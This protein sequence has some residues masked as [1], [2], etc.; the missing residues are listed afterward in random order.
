[1]TDATRIK[2]GLMGAAPDTGNMGVS[3]LCFSTVQG[4]CSNI[5]EAEFTVFDNGRGVRAIAAKVNRGSIALKYC[6]LVKS[7]KF[8][9]P[10]NVRLNLLCGLLPFRGPAPLEQIRSCNVVM[11]ISGGDSF[12]DLYGKSVFD[13]VALPQL[14]ALQ[15]GKPLVL[16]PQTYGPFINPEIKKTARKIVINSAMAW[17]RDENSF[18]ILRELLGDAFDP[19]RH[20]CGVD[21][22]FG[23]EKYKPELSP[24]A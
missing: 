13:Y 18:T 1:M 6:G 3:A 23:L 14:L 21:M 8:Y 11:A 22:A 2:I 16:L 19:D 5:P 15:Q 4:I 20:F 9:R 7:R 10:E 24:R 17:A 12:T